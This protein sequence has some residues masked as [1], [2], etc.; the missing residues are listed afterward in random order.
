MKILKIFKDFLKNFCSKYSKNILEL[1]P[2]KHSPKGTGV[3]HGIS[4][5]PSFQK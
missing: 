3:V 2:N 4:F 1:T 5:A